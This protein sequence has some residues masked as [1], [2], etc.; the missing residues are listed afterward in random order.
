M[1]RVV[2]LGASNLTLSF[3]LV[4]DTLRNNL[5]AP[6]EIWAAHGHGR[7][8][9]TWSRVLGRSLPGI[10]NCRLWNDLEQ[11]PIADRTTALLTDIGNDLLYGASVSQIIGWVRQCLEKLSSYQAQT[12]MTALPMDSIR[13]LSRARYNAA[14]SLFFP[15]SGVS[16]A[17]MMDRVQELNEAVAGTAEQ[18][19]ATYIE[20]LG[21]WY[22]FDPI[23]VV[24]RHRAAAW[25]RY[26]GSWFPNNHKLA[27]AKPSLR[28]KLELWR[29]RPAER[30][31]FGMKQTAVQPDGQ[32]QVWLY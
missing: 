25:S 17:D 3:A 2:L 1:Q 32:S 7:S 31:R 24:R 8:Y 20:P 10:S 13:R 21:E 14:R 9:G 30:F 4:V 15:S 11:Q 5:D 22:G 18:F 19:N 26:V 23:H 29:I 6:L 12:V 16:Y 28:R 27:I